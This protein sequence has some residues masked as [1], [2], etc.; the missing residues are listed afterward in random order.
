[1]NGVRASTKFAARQ[2]NVNLISSPFEA[3]NLPA[4]SFDFAM[5]NLDYHDVYWENEERKIP[6]MDPDAWLKTLY[7]AMKPAQW[8]ALSIMSPSRAATSARRSTSFT[9]STPKS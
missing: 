9:G 4:N 5:I 1:M 8:S 3:P 6:R 2:K 7:A